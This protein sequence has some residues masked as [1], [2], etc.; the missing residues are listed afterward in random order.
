MSSTLPARLGKLAASARVAW[1]ARRVRRSG[2]FDAPWYRAAYPDSAGWD[3]ATH[4]LAI[5]LWKGYRPHALFDAGWWRDRRGSRCRT[6]PFNDYLGTPERWRLSPSPYLVLEPGLDP[7]ALPHD[8]SPLGLFR[9]SGGTRGLVPSPLFDADFYARNNPD[10]AAA[11]FDPLLHFAANGG[12]EGR[13]PCVSFDA[14]RYLSANP[15]VKARGEEPLRHF[16][17][18]GARQGRAPH[19]AIDPALLLADAQDANLVEA[20]AHYQSEGRHRLDARTH[21]HL[22]PPGAVAPLFDDWPWRNAKAASTQ[23]RLLVLLAGP[24]DAAM[25]TTLTAAYR[26]GADPWLVSLDPAS[27]AVLETL[28]APMLALGQAASDI[29]PALLRAAVLAGP[30]LSLMI[31]ASP[32]HPVHALAARQSGLDI[33]RFAHP[34]VAATAPATALSISVV[35]PLYN[36]GTFIDQRLASILSQRR[37]PCEIIIID[38]ASQDD[39]LLRARAFAET[40]PM[41]VRIIA[42]EQNSGSP[43]MS[44]A[45]GARA[46]CGELLWIAESD[47]LADPRLLERL[48][49]FLEQ[50]ERVVLA[51][52]QSAVIGRHGERLA[53]DHLFYTD[54]IDAERWEAPYV[55]S[56]ETE[57]AEALAIKNTIPNASAVLFRRR[58]LAQVA[59]AIVA[60]RYCGDWR[61]YALLSARGWIGYSPEPLNLTRRHDANATLEGERNALALR[62]A[63]DIRLSLWRRPGIPVT[64]VRAGLAQHQREFRLLQERHGPLAGVD[65]AELDLSSGFE[66]AASPAAPA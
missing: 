35:V 26:S 1:A 55:V 36:H 11:G 14:F 65:T 13:S 50:D 62:E 27:D 47:D 37:A 54:E 29:L 57:I 64:A 9:E 59:K 12:R 31:A 43:F 8:A 24:P 40:A 44:W 53:D 7:N 34:P 51:Y 42:R 48:A 19:R 28:A 16:L 39:S 30:H 63:R 32:E 5:G 66:L 2:A 17:M 22:P 33:I 20:L 46:A 49:P 4:F 10:V 18:R 21:V 56:G 45:E 38:D 41:P 3:A 6:H 60:D 52:C 15:D 23:G 61:S 58:D 25:M